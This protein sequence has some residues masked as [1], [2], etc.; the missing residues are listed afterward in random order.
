MTAEPRHEWGAI[1]HVVRLDVSARICAKLTADL[2]A[3]EIVVHGSVKGNLHARDR[4][5]IKK[6]SSVVGDL[7][8]AKI[9]V[10]DGA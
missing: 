2:V 6:D 10:E 4:I 8:S 3:R 7:T 5:E 1:P 9:R